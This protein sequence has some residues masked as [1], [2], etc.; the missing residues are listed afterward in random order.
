MHKIALQDIFVGK[1][2]SYCKNIFRPIG[3][4][5][6]NIS[7]NIAQAVLLCVFL[8]FRSSLHSA[9]KFQAK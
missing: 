2:V 7:S 5:K 6:R 4:K 3:V 9:Q 8:K 1:E